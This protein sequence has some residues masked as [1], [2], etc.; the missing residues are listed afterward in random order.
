MTLQE[1]AASEDMRGQIKIAMEHPAMEI[2]LRAIEEDNMPELVIKAPTGMDI[3]DVIALDAAKRA[4]AQSVIRRLRKLPYLTS[5]KF[6]KAQDVG[7]PWEYLGEEPALV[8]SP[9]P[10]TPKS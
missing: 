7:R 10:K 4:G 5:G 9:K 6:S 3:M 1:I 8:K 2:A